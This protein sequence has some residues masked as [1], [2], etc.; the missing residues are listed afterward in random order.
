MPDGNCPTRYES[1]MATD[2]KNLLVHRIKAISGFWI[3]NL[4]RFLVENMK[5][6]QKFGDTFFP[7]ESFEQ[8]VFQTSWVFE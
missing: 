1:F 4:S 8:K 7:D 5:E 6:V 3:E 2:V